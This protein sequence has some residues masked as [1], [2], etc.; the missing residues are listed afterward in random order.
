MW[1]DGV[2]GSA[3]TTMTP[4][5]GTDTAYFIFPRTVLYFTIMDIINDIYSAGYRTTTR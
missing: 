3:S 2:L 1:K 5:T 4:H